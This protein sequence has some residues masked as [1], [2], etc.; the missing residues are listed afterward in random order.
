MMTRRSQIWHDGSRSII[1]SHQITTASA[2]AAARLPAA[3]ACSASR[4]LTGVWLTEKVCSKAG[5]S[6][7]GRCCLL[8]PA[9]SARREAQCTPSTPRTTHH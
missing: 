8:S 6:G 4:R 1:Y 9:A 3:A 5:A 2:A 7:H